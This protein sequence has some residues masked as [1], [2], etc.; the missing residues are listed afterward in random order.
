LCINVL[1]VRKSLFSLKQH[2]VEIFPIYSCQRSLF[3]KKNPIIR[4]F[5]V[6]G[7]LVV[8]INPDKWSSTAFTKCSIQPSYPPAFVSKTHNIQYLLPYRYHVYASCCGKIL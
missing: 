7:W 5:C 4:I 8:P 3:S 2:F 1:F 6:S